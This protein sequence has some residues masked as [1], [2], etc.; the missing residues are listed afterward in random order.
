[1]P[2]SAGPSVEDAHRRRAERL[3]GVP[4]QSGACTLQPGGFEAR[5]PGGAS[6]RRGE[7]RRSD[8]WHSSSASSRCHGRL[9]RSVG[10]RRALWKGASVA[11]CAMKARFKRGASSAASRIGGTQ[12]RGIHLIFILTPWS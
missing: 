12:L 11:A 10:F 7:A 5:P 3:K 8:Q 4:K 1:M 9:S 2:V 6:Q